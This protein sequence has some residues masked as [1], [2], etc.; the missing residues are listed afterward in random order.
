MPVNSLKIKLNIF[1]LGV[2]VIVG[3]MAVFGACGHAA[4]ATPPVDCS[5]SQSARGRSLCP[6]LAAMSERSGVVDLMAWL[7]NP[8]SEDNI[9]LSPKANRAVNDVENPDKISEV[10][11]PLAWPLFGAA[12]LGIGYLGRQRRKKPVHEE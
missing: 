12:L 3:G 9:S 5:K 2:A 7:F 11:L 4:A 6:D 1:G 8:A 10:P